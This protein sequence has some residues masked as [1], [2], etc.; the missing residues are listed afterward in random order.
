[1]LGCVCVQLATLGVSIIVS[2]GDDGAQ[3]NSPDGSDPIGAQAL[4]CVR[5]RVHV[6]VCVCICMCVRACACLSVCVRNEC[7]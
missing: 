1:M 6:R 5:V 7:V 4:V 3:S 2:D